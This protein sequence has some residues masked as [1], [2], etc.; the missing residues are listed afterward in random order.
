[1]AN[2][3]SI[4]WHDVV[5]ALNDDTETNAMLLSSVSASEEPPR[6]PTALYAAAIKDLTAAGKDWVACLDILPEPGSNQKTRRDGCNRL[7][8]ENDAKSRDT[9][10]QRYWDRYDYKASGTGETVSGSVY[11][12][13]A[14]RHVLGVQ[15]KNAIKLIDAWS[16]NDTVKSTLQQVLVFNDVEYNMSEMGA[17]RAKTIRS[18]LTSRFNKLADNFRTMAGVHRN[19]RDIETRMEGIVEVEFVYNVE[20]NPASGLAELKEPIKIVM[21]NQVPE[22][23]RFGQQTSTCR[24]FTSKAFANLDVDQAIE[25]GGEKGASYATLIDSKKVKIK[26]G[27]GASTQEK[28]KAEVE[29]LI[30]SRNANTIFSNLRIFTEQDGAK[31]ALINRLKEMDDD[32]RKAFYYDMV[33]VMNFFGEF[34]TRDANRIHDEEKE[35]RDARALD[36]LQ[37]KDRAAADTAAASNAPTQNDKAKEWRDRNMA[38]HAAGEQV[39]KPETTEPATTPAEQEDKKETTQAPRGGRRG[40]RPTSVA[41]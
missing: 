36:E 3:N 21:L 35:L 38:I 14:A 34:Q 8:G 31:R 30:T 1:M 15:I 13:M 37:D 27:K 40:G 6:S 9:N 41:K 4:S 2:G 5:D 29:G 19:K 7:L 11:S 39:L 12:D 18:T 10:P 20:G 22:S 33:E 25:K 17:D 16:D 23:P 32:D 28:G 26:V 24:A